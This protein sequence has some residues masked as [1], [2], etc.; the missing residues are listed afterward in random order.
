MNWNNYFDHIFV[1]TY[2]KNSLRR[3]LLECEFSRVNIK[4]FEYV[5]N[6]TYK[7]AVIPNLLSVEQ[8]LNNCT[9]AHYQ[10]IK[11]SYELGYENIL[12]LEDDIRFLKN[13]NEIEEIINKYPPPGKLNSPYDE[14]HYDYVL[15]PV[16]YTDFY[17][18]CTGSMYSLNQK[19]MKYAIDMLE[20]YEI[21]ADMMYYTNMNRARVQQPAWNKTYIF[22]V[23]S[24]K[25]FNNTHVDKNVCIQINVKDM[26]VE[27]LNLDISQYNEYPEDKNI[28]LKS[29]DN[30]I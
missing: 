7:Y 2:T 16:L 14:V 18:Y 11:N 26:Y 24:K 17:I 6:T 25:E 20:K 4:D 15:S 29:I 13:V 5:Y 30:N 27:N 1:I 22:E 23:P 19:G 3:E 21:G 12:I 9:F 10:T 28:K 8:N